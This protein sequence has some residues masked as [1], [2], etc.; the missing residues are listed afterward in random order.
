MISLE[1]RDIYLMLSGCAGS[2]LEKTGNCHLSKVNDDKDAETFHGC[3]HFVFNN[4][5]CRGS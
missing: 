4:L 3:H 2:F 5:Y 1:K